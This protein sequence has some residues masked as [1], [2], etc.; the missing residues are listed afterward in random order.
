MATRSEA[1][2]WISY[3]FKRIE[4]LHLHNLST[5]FA[6]RNLI[7]LMRR[8]E[9][10]ESKLPHLRGVLSLQATAIFQKLKG[11]NR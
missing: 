7:N 10:T 9:H 5:M 4:I 8:S 11:N 3:S 6:G 1:R 2:K